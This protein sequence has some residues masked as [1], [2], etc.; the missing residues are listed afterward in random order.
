M[1]VKW[2]RIITQLITQGTA[3]E[4][5]SDLTFQTFLSLVTSLSYGLLAC[6][7]VAK[8]SMNFKSISLLSIE[9][10]SSGFNCYSSDTNS[11]PSGQQGSVM[12]QGSSGSQGS[13]L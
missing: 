5:A 6:L 11:S 4:I 13:I 8:Y 12:A 2:E 7:L 1:E 3:Q 9:S 10:Q